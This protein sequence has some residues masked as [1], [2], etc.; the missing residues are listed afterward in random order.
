MRLTRPLLDECLVYQNALKEY[1]VD[2]DHLGLVDANI[3]ITDDIYK[4]INLQHNILTELIVPSFHRL[5]TLLLSNN[6]LTKVLIKAPNL[7][8]ISLNG[9]LFRDIKDVDIQSS[10][11]ENMSL[12]DTPLETIKNYR[13]LVIRKFTKL[14]ILDYEKVKLVERQS[15]VAIDTT[16]TELIPEVDA[17][18][19][20]LKKQLINASTLEEI[21]QIEHLIVMHK[22]RK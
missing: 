20:N 22:N 9:N 8:I 15:D 7:R 13:L 10:S 16:I 14:N 11:L 6:K 5:T 1:S 2:I 3:S 19:S 18:L 17:V 12:H 4:C 21:Q